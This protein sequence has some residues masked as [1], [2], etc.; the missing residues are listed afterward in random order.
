MTLAVLPREH[1]WCWSQ[2][3]R[4]CPAAPGAGTLGSAQAGLFRLLLFS[5]AQETFPGALWSWEEALSLPG[6]GKVLAQVSYGLC[7]QHLHDVRLL[8]ALRF[9]AEGADIRGRSF[10]LFSRLH[11]EIRK[12]CVL[13]SKGSV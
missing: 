1:L 13:R 6:M 2:S 5:R 9:D 11:P 12:P 10:G 3:S 7:E 8:P 4:A